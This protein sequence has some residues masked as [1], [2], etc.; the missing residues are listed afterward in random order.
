M[1][2]PATG[3]YLITSNKDHRLIGRNLKE[4]R[5]LLPKGV[6]HLP[7]NTSDDF[8]DSGWIVEKEGDK[9]KLRARGAPTGVGGDHYVLAFLLSEP[10]PEQWVIEP[11]DQ[12]NV[13]II[14]THDGR[15]GWTIEDPSADG[16]RIKVTNHPDKF[17]FTPVKE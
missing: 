5:S 4:D 10:A 11:T 17:D 14:K 16:G 6:F 7:T 1:S 9:Y 12:A 13:Y 15:L 8:K 2:L 3:H